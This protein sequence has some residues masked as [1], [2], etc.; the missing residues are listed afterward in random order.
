MVVGICYLL[1]GVGKF[2][3]YAFRN[4]A[5]SVID[6]SVESGIWMMTA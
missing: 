2:L 5:G 1:S 3:R 4:I 6:V